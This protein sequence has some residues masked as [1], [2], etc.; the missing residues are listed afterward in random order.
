MKLNSFQR[1]RRKLTLTLIRGYLS[2][3][4][5]KRTVRIALEEEAN[6]AAFEFRDVRKKI[7]D[8]ELKRELIYLR[9]ALKLYIDYKL[10]TL[11]KMPEETTSPVQT[12]FTIVV[13]GPKDMFL[14]ENGKQFVLSQINSII[15][16]D[17]RRPPI[18]ETEHIRVHGDEQVSH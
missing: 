3:K 9:E 7:D 8:I 17:E 15:N 16:T 11:E 5:R 18:G 12:Y 1:N 4:L 14:T 10:L 2:L 13:E 6:N